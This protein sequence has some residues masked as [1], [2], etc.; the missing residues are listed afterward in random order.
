MLCF[1]PLQP[2]LQNVLKHREFEA[3]T[4][5]L[6]PRYVPLHARLGICQAS[7][8]APSADVK[9]VASSVAGSGPSRKLWSGRVEYL[10]RPHNGV[11]PPTIVLPNSAQF[12]SLPEAEQLK[13]IQEMMGLLSEECD[14]GG[15]QVQRGQFV[16]KGSYAPHFRL[17]SMCQTAKLMCEDIRYTVRQGL[18]QCPAGQ[19]AFLLQPNLDGL[20]FRSALF[21]NRGKYL[22]HTLESR[23][24]LPPTREQQA[25]MDDAPPPGAQ[26]LTSLMVRARALAFNAGP[27][28]PQ[29]A[30]ELDFACVTRVD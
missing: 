15:W 28:Q 27:P 10:H 8:A 24:N 21:F 3:L 20:A 16:L 22:F 1:P 9:P 30:H 29:P 26:I 23:D 2:Q 6:L 4:D 19:S 14:S 12:V 11:F 13:C 18:A 7:V 17:I 5:P 25:H